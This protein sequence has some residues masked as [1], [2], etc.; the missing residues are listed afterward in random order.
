[1]AIQIKYKAPKTITISMT[2]KKKKST[3]PSFF[4]NPLYTCFCVKKKARNKVPGAVY[5]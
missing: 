4:Q 1:M 5:L 3:L 2:M